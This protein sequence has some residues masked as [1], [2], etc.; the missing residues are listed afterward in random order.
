[1]Q[2]EAT[3]AIRD[4]SLVLGR[5]RLRQSQAEALLVLARLKIGQDEPREARKIARR[6]ARLFAGRGSD[7]WAARAQAVA[8]SAEV[9]T[10]VRRAALLDE[11][12]NIA[13]QLKAQ[14][15]VHDA[16]AVLLQSARMAIRLD[17]LPAARARVRSVRQRADAP[18]EN[19]LL[20]HQVK[21]ELAKATR[22]RKPAM[23]HVR[24]GLAEL[25]DWQSSF[26]SLDLQSSLVGHGRGLAAEGLRLAV[27]DGR[28][29]VVFEWTER[30]R[31]LTSR[32]AAVRPP[33]NPE[34]AAQLQELRE[35]HA[36]IRA[37]DADGR[38]VTALV[39]S[40]SALQQKIREKAWHDPGSGVVTEPATLDAL[41]PQLAKHNGVMVTHL[42]THGG[43]LR[44]LVATGD[45]TRVVDLGPWDDVKHILRGLQADLDVSAAHLPEPLRAVVRDS[46][47]DRL[48][49]LSERLLAPVADLLSGRPVLV[50]PTGGLAG[51]PWTLLPHLRGLPVTQ[52]RSAT[53]WLAHQHGPDHPRRRAAF[54]AGPRVDR[55]HEEVRRAAAAWGE[56]GSVLEAAD[57]S[58]EQ[59]SAR[60]ADADVLHVAAHG[61][62]SA[63]NPLFSGLELADGP[64]FGYDI[65]RLPHVPRTVV[66]S[67]CE[68][69]RSTVRWGEEAIGMTQAW[70][71]AG[72]CTVIASPASVDD[73]VACEVLAETHA[74]LAAGR[75]PAYALADATQRL[76]LGDRSSFMCFGAGW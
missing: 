19:R 13:G 29:E 44:V 8:L 22:R 54:V 61:R 39:R 11:A 58:A 23:Q 16:S 70:L 28:P 52:P 59:V 32:V 35:L 4:A 56:Q 45:E 1:M 57:A 17:D 10:G 30:A 31:A 25:H 6:A 51:T 46:L 50:V 49:T 55:A 34:G 60:A 27:E 65:D 2:H 36:Q 15:L 76:G 40:A 69:G 14:G 38:P 66:L 43:R 9:L 72:A 12:A 7:A 74:G 73:D 75:L 42:A 68:L 24:D 48:A 62:H 33:D 41:L 64:W 67:A 18:L 71:H 26:G 63:D 20:Q 21:A 37:A 5:R 47:G 3:D 53:L